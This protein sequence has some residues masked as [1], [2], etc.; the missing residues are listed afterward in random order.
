METDNV[1]ETKTKQK[2]QNKIEIIIEK[3]T[4]YSTIINITTIERRDIKIIK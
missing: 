1:R 2:K 4:K 3:Q